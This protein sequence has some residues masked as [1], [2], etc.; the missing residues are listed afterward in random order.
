LAPGKPG[1]KTAYFAVQIENNGKKGEWGPLVS[2]L[3]P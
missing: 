2:A 1:R 3:I